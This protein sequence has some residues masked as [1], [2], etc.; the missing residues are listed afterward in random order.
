MLVLSRK[1]QEAVIVDGTAGFKELLKVTVLEIR[2]GCVKLGFEVAPEIP[3]HRWEVWQR[4][5]NRDATGVEPA[6]RL[7]R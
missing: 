7:P 2:N 1:P 5:Q 4:I 3:V 6:T